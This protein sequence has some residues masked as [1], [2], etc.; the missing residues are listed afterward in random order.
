MDKL[1]PGAA[2]IYERADGDALHRGKSQQIRFF[3]GGG[4][5]PRVL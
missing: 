1:I 4:E 5:D 2:L 3:D